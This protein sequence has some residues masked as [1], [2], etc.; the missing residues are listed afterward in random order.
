M[1]RE[2]LANLLNG[3]QYRQEITRKEEK[4]AKDN[5]LIVIFGASDDLCEIVG[6]LNDEVDC[7]GGGASYTY[8]NAPINIEWN[9][10]GYSWVYETSLPHSTFEIFED[11]EKYC[12]GIVIDMLEVA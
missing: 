7:Y 1:N 10:D 4:I 3:R 12:R 9:K 8:F 5:N 2:E 6:A 11:E